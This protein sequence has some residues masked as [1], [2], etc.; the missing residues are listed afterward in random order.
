MQDFAAS[1][2]NERFVNDG[3]DTRLDYLVRHGD[4]VWVYS[5]RLDDMAGLR[6]QMADARAL[7]DVAQERDLRRGIKLTYIL[8]GGLILAAL[9]GAAGLPGAPHQPAH[10]AADRGS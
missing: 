7:V 9:A 6:R 10:P 5:A 4:E 1:D 2:E 8:L 3:Q